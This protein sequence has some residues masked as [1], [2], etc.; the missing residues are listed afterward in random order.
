MYINEFEYYTPSWDLD[1]RVD[2][3][4]HHGAQGIKGQLKIGLIDQL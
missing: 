2:S 1:G 4:R 3:A